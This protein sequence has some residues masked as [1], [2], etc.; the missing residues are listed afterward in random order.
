MSRRVLSRFKR[1]VSEIHRFSQRSTDDQPLE[2]GQNGRLKNPPVEEND[3]SSSGPSEQAWR[4]LRTRGIHN[5][6]REKVYQ[7]QDGFRGG[8][9]GWR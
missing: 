4:S 1:R 3:K 8:W 5:G 7:R 9:A 6:D 2:A